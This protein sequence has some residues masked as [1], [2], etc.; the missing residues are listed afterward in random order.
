MD[1]F[2]HRSS[3][4]NQQDQSSLIP[5]AERMRPQNPD[6]FIGQ[7][8][9][10]GKGKALRQVL[11][12]NLR[13][14]LIFWGPPGSGKTTLA[15]MIAPRMS[16][17]FV[18]YSAVISG[19]KQIKDVIRHAD[20]INKTQQ[21]PTILFVDEIHR[22]NKAQQDAFLPNVENG[23]IILIGATTENPS[24]EVIPALLSR[25][26]VIVLK[27]LEHEHLYQILR[28]AIEDNEKGIGHLKP[29]ISEDTIRF[30]A[31]SAGGDARVALNTLE[32]AMQL[33]VP[34]ENGCRRV[35]AELMAQALQK[36]PI[37][38][39]KSGDQ[40]FNLISAFHKSLRG[41]DP[42]AALYW[43]ARMMSGG[44]EPLYILRRMIRFASED[45]GLA[46]PRALTVAVAARD[47]YHF[48][49]SPEGDLALAQCA[50]YLASAP[51]SNRIDRAY[52]QAKKSAESSSDLPV[53]MH[54]RNAPTRLMKD[55]GYGNGYVYDHDRPEGYAGQEFLPDELIG[56][57]F[58]QPS[59]FG[60][61]KEIEKRL[62]WW[63][64]KKNQSTP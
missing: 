3:Q 43:L 19:I 46:D 13:V 2:T 36:R 45:I 17:H 38:Y 7:D 51:K 26:R 27:P 44:E 37:M 10:L 58:Y 31:E 56:T 50:V 11:E 48:L 53:P 16:K 63:K 28:A 6:T 18:E 54:I 21:N 30:L 42:D 24:F 32:F 1:L 60:F 41:S 55:L 59:E 35:D 47:S 20:F 62:A 15:R 14:S 12:N 39:D 34:D 57:V 9:I 29:D 49:G 23:T 52:I 33:A 61:E 4:K 22:F 64:R 8:H 5:L 25:T 40:H